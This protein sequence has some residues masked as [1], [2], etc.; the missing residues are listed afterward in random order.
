VKTHETQINMYGKS[1]NIKKHLSKI[2]KKIVGK[3]R[4]T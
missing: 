3:N 2:M 1:R 4:E